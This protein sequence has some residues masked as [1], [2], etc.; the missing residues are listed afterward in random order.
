MQGG[1]LLRTLFTAGPLFLTVIRLETGFPSP[2]ACQATVVPTPVKKSV[3]QMELCSVGGVKLLIP[4][5]HWQTTPP[6]FTAPLVSLYTHTL[7]HHQYILTVFLHISCAL[8]LF[9][10]AF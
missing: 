6:V 10:I 8:N 5:S 7:P 4:A 2:L 3:L 1:P 9:V